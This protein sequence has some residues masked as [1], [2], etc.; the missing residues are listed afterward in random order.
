[1]SQLMPPNVYHSSHL[2]AATSL[3]GTQNSNE[4]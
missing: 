2:V 3:K 4:D 1:M